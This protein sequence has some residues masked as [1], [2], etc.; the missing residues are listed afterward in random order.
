M[1]LARAA[2]P[3]RRLQ[4]ALARGLVEPEALPIPA[5][6][7]AGSQLE[8]D[9]SAA[10]A[11]ITAP[12]Q[13]APLAEAGQLAAALQTAG[14]APTPGPTPANP[15]SRAE[16]MPLRAGPAPFE[17]A[18]RS[19]LQAADPALAQANR[20]SSAPAESARSAVEPSSP[21][22][23]REATRPA[24]VQVSDASSL[25]ERARGEAQPSAGTCEGASGL[26][27]AAGSVRFVL[28]VTD[29]RGTPL[30]G[31][32]IEVLL[33]E[34]ERPLLLQADE[35]GRVALALDPGRYRLRRPGQPGDAR[36]RLTVR[37]GL[38]SVELEL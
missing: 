23:A 25:A 4:P 16:G 27:S 28:T 14:I 22:S 30:P 38:R 17:T 5:E 32:A 2:E 12:T 1:E 8:A 18:E 29:R 3:E 15:K 13:P 33:G 6:L 31:Q 9:A 21:A 10:T 36:A 20:P 7:A 11:R 37:E 24:A 19:S 35:R 26:G 34:G